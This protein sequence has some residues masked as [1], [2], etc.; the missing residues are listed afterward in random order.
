MNRK[1]I[2]TKFVEASCTSRLCSE[3]LWVFFF[4]TLEGIV[5][6]KGGVRM[7]EFGSCERGQVILSQVV[8]NAGRVGVGHR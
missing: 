4:L 1:V 8:N 2:Y 5:L 7:K 3:S 6:L